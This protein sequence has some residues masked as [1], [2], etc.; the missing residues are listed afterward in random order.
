M[1]LYYGGVIMARKVQISKE[2]ILQAALE[3]LIQEGYLAVNIKTLAK[4]IG[5][6]TQPIVWQ[7]D[8]MEGFRKALTEYA[9]SYANNKMCPS[10]ENAIEAFEQVGI[11]FL[12]IAANESNLFRFLYLDGYSGTCANNFD[13]LIKDED[14]SVLIK[15]I[16][17]YFQISEESTG[18]YLQNTIIY[19]HGI[20]SL[21]ATGVIKASIE[22]MMLMINS[23]GD[24]FLLQAGVPMHKI[25][26]HIRGEKK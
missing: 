3:L 20:A 21:V 6:S 2:M 1:N 23:V 16:V 26:Q 12:K 22:E 14:N 18:R 4:K 24:A 8:N 19:T 25:P 10:A 9:L 15:R 5:C 13:A 11:A 17:E 7:F